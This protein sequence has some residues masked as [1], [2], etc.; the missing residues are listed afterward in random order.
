[1]PLYDYICAACGRRF[2]VIHGV[3]DPAPEACPLCGKPQVIRIGRFGKFIA[4]SG[5][6]ECKYTAKYVEKIEAKC[7]EDGGDIVLLRTKKGRPFY[8]CSNYPTCKFMSWTIPGKEGE[9]EKPKR[10]RGKKIETAV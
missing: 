9:G 7:P 8:G 2:E 6:P 4:C 10:G 3:N 1:M 5:Y